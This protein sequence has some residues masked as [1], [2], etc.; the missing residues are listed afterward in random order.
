[1][2]ETRFRILLIDNDTAISDTLHTAVE[3]FDRADNLQDGLQRLAAGEINIILLA[4]SLPDSQGLNTFI[5]VQAQAPD[6]PI[7]ILANTE[8][9]ALVVQTLNA[10]AQDFVFKDDI[11]PHTLPH[12]LRHAIESKRNEEALRESE[13]R[14]RTIT[15]GSLAGVYIIQDNVFR[16]VNPALARIF[17]YRQR[18]LIDRLGL[19]DLVHPD[20]RPIIHDYHHARLQD[21]ADAVFYTMRGIKKDGTDI[22]CEVSGRRTEYQEHVAIVGTLMDITER[23]RAE[24]AL[25]RHT[26][27]LKTMR[28]IDRAILQSQSPKDI[29][30]AALHHIRQLVPYTEASVVALDHELQEGLVLAAFDVTGERRAG[31]RQPLD[32][33]AF[34]D[35]FRQGQIQVSESAIQTYVSLPLIAHGKLIGAFDI[36]REGQGGFSPEQIDIAR[37]VADLLAVAIHNANLY[38]AAQHSANELATLYH[39]TSILFSAD[40]LSEMC[41]QI[42]EVVTLAFSQPHCSVLLVDEERQ[43]IVSWG[44]AGIF[45]VESKAECLLNNPENVSE[46]VRRRQMIY[47]PNVTADHAFCD[48]RT[49][50]ELVVPLRTGK[51]VIGV[52][53]LQSQATDAFSERNQ[54]VLTAFAERAATAVENMQLVEAIRQHAAD[55]EQRVIE[56]TAQLQQTTERVETILNNSS[57]AILFAH[58]DGSI[59]QVNP[60]LCQLFGYRAQDVQGKSLTL[61][62]ASEWVTDLRIALVAVSENRQP[63]RIDLTAQR[64]DGTLFDADMALSATTEDGQVAGIVCSVRDITRRRQVEDSLRKALNRERELGEMKSRFVSM[65]SHEFRTPLTTIRVTTDLLRNYIDRM[66]ETQRNSNFDK[67]QGEIEHL[68]ALLEDVLTIGKAESGTMEFNPTRLNLDQF[69]R[70]ILDEIQ[71]TAAVAIIYT[72]TIQ[73]ETSRVDAKLM[74]QIITNL[75]L[76]AIKYS[77]DESAVYIDLIC[78]PHRLVLRV[79]DEGIGIPAHEQELIFDAFHRADNVGMIPGTGLGLAITQQ[80]VEL[81]RGTITLESQAGVGTTFTVTIPQSENNGR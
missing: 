12:T 78:E 60:A 70:D 79:T 81:H 16:Y 48:P 29:S 9:E 25:Q 42:A 63:Q 44:Q 13:E 31:L 18:E 73:A 19:L 76:N 46:A 3:N 75:V 53:D 7:I 22:Y 65:A 80:A 69:C 5:R 38:D 24:E 35:E 56:R 8:D 32:S 40:N 26:E 4:L 28:E 54:R 33:L 36:G 66:D 61:L 10:G 17:G 67:I 58:P 6:L 15:E 47:V 45:E 57:D 77:A 68:T 74:R 11:D 27:R 49:R 64:N 39:A 55:L 14:F 2:V 71:Q 30:Q 20:D 52:L 34:S 41:N 59:Q 62:V 37:E 72:P 50:S 23:K 21:E 51:G 43:S 1:M